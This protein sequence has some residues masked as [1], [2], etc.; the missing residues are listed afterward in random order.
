MQFDVSRIVPEKHF[1]INGTSY[2]GNP[3]SNTAMY[4]T[5]KVEYLLE[6]LEFVSECLIFTDNNIDVPDIV[7]QKNAIVH[8]SNPQL[9]YAKFVTSFAAERFRSEKGLKFKQTGSGYFISE[10]CKIGERAY[11]EPGCI[12]GPDVKIGK[13]A[14]ILAGSVIR[15]AT[16]GDNFY[17]NEYAVVG[18]NGFTMAEDENGNRIR[19]PTLG[20]VIIGNNVEIGTHD[21]ISCG[22]SGDTIIENNVKI[23]ALVHIGHDVHLHRNVDIT[24]GG[25]IGGFDELGEHS[26]VGINA[27]LRNRITV[28][29]R[30]V[31]GM[32][33]TV[34]RSVDSGITVVGNPARLHEKK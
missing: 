14:V 16:I 31:I 33:S 29:E 18:A 19:I 3:K 27:V 22:S 30:A 6:T 15:R 11:I 8:T 26:Y 21:N 9:D 17:A 20:R 2:I 13:N 28:G 10:D 7:A 34:T 12:I 24:A 25:I 4:I 23:D 5:K 32:G 1:S